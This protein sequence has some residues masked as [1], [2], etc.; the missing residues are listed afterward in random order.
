MSFSICSKTDF[1]LCKPR[2][3]RWC[4]KLNDNK[5]KQIW[6]THSIIDCN[7]D[8]RHQIVTEEFGFRSL[9]S[10]QNVLTSV[11]GMVLMQSRTGLFRMRLIKLL[12]SHWWSTWRREVCFTPVRC[13]PSCATSH[14]RGD[15]FQNQ[16][17]MVWHGV[18]TSFFPLPKRPVFEPTIFCC[19][20]W[21]P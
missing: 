12:E 17:G 4:G 8:P 10:R 21:R 19:L 13:H 11:V 16:L 20:Y 5:L 2:F 1:W 18:K 15:V 3:V 7:S 14:C 9:C 6:S